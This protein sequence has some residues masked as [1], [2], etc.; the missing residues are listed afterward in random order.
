MDFYGRIQH[1]QGLQHLFNEEFHFTPSKATKR[2][3]F[4]LAWRKTGPRYCQVVWETE[5]CAR[6]KENYDNVI[7][8]DESSICLERHR[9]ICFSKRG[10]PPKL[11]PK[12]KHPY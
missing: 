1:S 7:F 3:R 5:L 12:A 2:I 6:N 9:Q 8:T 4:K 11:K 10:M